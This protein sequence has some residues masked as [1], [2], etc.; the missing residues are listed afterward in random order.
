MTAD[1]LAAAENYYRHNPAEIEEAI[2]ANE[3]P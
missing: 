3:E 2:R 1:D